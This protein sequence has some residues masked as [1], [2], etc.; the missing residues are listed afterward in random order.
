MLY[1]CTNMSMGETGLSLQ[2]CSIGDDN[3]NIITVGGG[4]EIKSQTCPTGGRGRL[5]LQTCLMGEIEGSRWGVEGAQ[6]GED[7]ADGA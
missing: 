1:V 3:N 6:R 5:E 2:A 4:S 7:S